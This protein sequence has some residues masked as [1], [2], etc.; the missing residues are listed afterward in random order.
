MRVLPERISS[1]WIETLTD[2]DL[3]ELEQR[4]RGRFDVL[5]KREKKLRGDKYNMM[6]GSAELMD[7][8]DR[9]S[10]LSAATRYRSLTPLKP[11]AQE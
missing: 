7:A 4:Q 2:T 5:E 9:W 1:T 10:R 11:A 6:R 8:W 3:L